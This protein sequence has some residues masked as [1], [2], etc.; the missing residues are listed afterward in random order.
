M[1]IARISP[2]CFY[3]AS[4]V[5]LWTG[6]GEVLDWWQRTERWVRSDCFHVD[7]PVVHIRQGTRHGACHC[8]CPARH[9]PRFSLDTRA[10]CGL[11]QPAGGL[12][13]AH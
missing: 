4:P 2:T 12:W 10:A 3:H 11:C 7:T 9:C 6:K 13:A 8:S 1:P 5:A